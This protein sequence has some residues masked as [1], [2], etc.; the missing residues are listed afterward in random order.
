MIARRYAAAERLARGGL[1]VAGPA[2]RAWRG[3]VPPA[4]PGQLPFTV[5]EGAAAVY[6]PACINRIF[7]NGDGR[8]AHPTVP[9]ALVAV[10]RRVGLPLWIPDDVGGHCCGVPWSSKGYT[11]GF[12]VMAERIRAALARWTDGGALPVVI[13]AS[14]CSH[15][16]VSDV[17]PEGIA[18]LDSIEWVHDR[19]LERLSIARKLGTVVVHPTCSAMHLGLARKLTAIAGELGSEVV[20]PAATGCCGMAGDRGWLHPELP[21][22]ALGELARELDGSSYDACVSSNRTCE[23]ALRE[24]TGQPYASFVLALEELTRG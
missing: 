3:S 17:A 11:Q 14:S 2:I 9:E 21:A 10:S 7:G 23:V 18:I 20:V 8:A 16:L 22:S 4:A 1:R 5:R 15:G 6:M 13:D 12:E 19:L 24:V